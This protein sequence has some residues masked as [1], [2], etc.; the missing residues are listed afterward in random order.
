MNASAS[1]WGCYGLY[2]AGC[3]SCSTDCSTKVRLT[4]YF[5]ET[6]LTLLLVHNFAV[7]FFVWKKFGLDIM[8]R[9]ATVFMTLLWSLPLFDPKEMNYI[10]LSRATTDLGLIRNFVV[11]EVIFEIP[12][13]L[14]E[15]DKT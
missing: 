9:K 12:L 13:P 4:K 15:D 5:T 7:V 8:F 3:P 6:G 10:V 2:E 1:F 14:V 11:A